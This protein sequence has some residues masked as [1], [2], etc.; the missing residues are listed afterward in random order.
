MTDLA[1]AQHSYYRAARAARRD[2]D[3]ATARHLERHAEQIAIYL[4]GGTA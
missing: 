1:A 4:M 3:H 2:N